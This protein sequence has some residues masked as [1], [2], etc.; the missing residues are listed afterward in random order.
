LD[1]VEEQVLFIFRRNGTRAVPP[2]RE[3]TICPHGEGQ[4]KRPAPYNSPTIQLALNPNIHKN[5]KQPADWLKLE[6]T[7]ELITELSNSEDSLNKLAVTREGSGGGTFAHKLLPF[8]TLRV[9]NSTGIKSCKSS[10]Y[11]LSRLR[12][13]IAKR[14]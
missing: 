1:L 10:I 8:P 5:S 11:R 3:N 9:L 12:F 6:Q 2:I 4:G 13:E 14:R 7:K